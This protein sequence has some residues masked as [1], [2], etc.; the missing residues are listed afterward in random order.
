[1]SDAPANWTPVHHTDGEEPEEGAHTDSKPT[2]T[3]TDGKGN[4]AQSPVS[5]T[6]NLPEEVTSAI[7]KL[8]KATED[9]TKEVRKLIVLLTKAAGGE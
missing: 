6:L 2:K 8:V 1:M 7:G 3:K 4:G 5:L 9:N